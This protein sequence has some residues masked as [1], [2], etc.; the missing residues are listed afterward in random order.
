MELGCFSI[1]PGWRCRANRRA[2]RSEPCERV[3]QAGLHELTTKLQYL[4]MFSV[5]ASVHLV[6]RQHLRTLL[7]FR[8]FQTLTDKSVAAPFQLLRVPCE[9]VSMFFV[10]CQKDMY[11]TN[12]GGSGPSVVS[13][14]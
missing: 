1:L 8:L 11:Q 10:S 9:E 5:V 6:C 7:C 13:G 4:S 14:L 12:E 3:Q 2:N